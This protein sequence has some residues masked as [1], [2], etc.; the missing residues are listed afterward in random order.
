LEEDILGGV[1]AYKSLR[2]GH[3]LT[4]WSEEDCQWF[5]LRTRDLAFRNGGRCQEYQFSAS[6]KAREYL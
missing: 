4:Q 2:R 6:Q 5:L 1:L 3:R